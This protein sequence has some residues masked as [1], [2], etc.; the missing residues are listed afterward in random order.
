MGEHGWREALEGH[1]IIPGELDK[2][3]SPGLAGAD[4]TSLDLP[5]T[6]WPTPVMTLDVSAVAHNLAEMRAWTRDRGILLAPHGKT[7][8]CPGLWAWQLAAGAWAITVANE[9]QLRVA[10]RHGAPRVVVAN[11]L[12]SPT[13]LRW[14]SAEL[15]AEPT[16]DVVCW[17]DS[18]ASVDL[19]TKHLTAAGAGRPVG[20]CVE[21]GMPGVRT[22]ARTITDAIA[23]AQA[24]AA[25]PMLALR[26]IAG[27]E[28]NAP[29]HTAIARAEAAAEFL[30]R[31]GGAFTAC[32]DLFETETP[33][34]SAGGSAYFDLVAGRLGPAV[35][36]V[37]GSRIVLRSGCY[38]VHDDGMYRDSTPRAARGGP[39]FRAAA[40]VWS[41]VLSA[42][43]PDRALLDVGR[44]DVPFDAGL[45][46][47]LDVLR[48]TPGA[49]VRVGAEGLRATDINDQHLFLH[50]QTPGALE[51]GDVVRL[52]VSHPCTLFD[53]W[54]TVL[55]T[56][57]STPGAVRVRGAVTTRF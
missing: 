32:A 39:E 17:V 40:H 51:V 20:V 12:V 9:F 11:E 45:P 6:G 24:V 41:T 50:M 27:Y 35:D 42:P 33:L 44:R 28:G 4:A 53:K 47:P 36:A 18:V 43:E 34:V 1:L 3:W 23:A 21:L 57:G 38:L 56:E 48:L 13:G 49:D 31:L 52:G 14:L 37:P 7:T 15:D 55:L 5:L 25:S 16:F 54:R 26:G 30:D 22:G 2:S 29:G 8:M 19:M 46:L 10:R